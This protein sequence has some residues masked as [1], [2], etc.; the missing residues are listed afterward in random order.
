MTDMGWI[1]VYTPYSRH[2]LSSAYGDWQ[3]VLSHLTVERL[4]CGDLR[5]VDRVIRIPL[6]CAYG[7][8]S[9]A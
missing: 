6:P 4:I 9:D 7:M 2:R 1:I 5:Y 8:M 3:S